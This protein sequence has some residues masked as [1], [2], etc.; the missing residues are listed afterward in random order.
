[1]IVTPC[2]KGTKI[3]FDQYIVYAQLDI[4]MDNACIGHFEL[5]QGYEFVVTHKFPITEGEGILYFVVTCKDKTIRRKI[6][7]PIFT[8][9]KNRKIKSF[10]ALYK[11]YS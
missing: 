7:I 8:K 10:K 5:K 4:L 11:R 3:S 1:M 6:S 2:L 9:W